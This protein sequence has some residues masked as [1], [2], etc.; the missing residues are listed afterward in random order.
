MASALKGRLKR[1]EQRFERVLW[2]LRLIAIL[3]VVMSLVSTVVSFVLGTLEIGK[4]LAVFGHQ[5]QLDKKFVAELLG[6]IVSGIDL[7]LIGIAL[8]IFG[9]GVYELLISPIEA[10]RE[11][12]QGGGG[13]LDIRNLDQLKEKLVKVLVVALIVSAFKAMLTLPIK[14]GPSLAFFSLS[15]LLLALSGYLV[16]GNADK[17]LPR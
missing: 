1:M 17:V 2:R 6:A 16:T 7:Y 8:L 10:A 4:A 14:D 3:P 12:D 9:Y 13:L 5:D 11:H 15:V